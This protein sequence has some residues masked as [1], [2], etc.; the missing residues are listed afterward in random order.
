M[1]FNHTSQ[2]ALTFSHLTLWAL[3]ALAQTPPPPTPSAPVSGE[4]NAATGKR[5]SIT[6]R[7]IGEDG[8]PMTGVTVGF[9][10]AMYDRNGSRS[11]T[12]DED[13]NFKANN[14]P[15]GTYRV[16]TSV[17]GFVSA[18]GNV[19]DSLLTET[20]QRYRLG[21]HVTITMIKGG[22]I[23]GKVLDG[24]GQ[25]LVGA[26][27]SAI[28]VRD[29]D[30]RAV[31]EAQVGGRPGVSDDR[32]VYRL[33]GLQA[34]SYVVYTNGGGESL[35]M[36]A[37]SREVTTYHPAATRDTAQEVSVAPGL[38]ITGIDIRHRGEA[39][40]A[41][42]GTIQGTTDSGNVATFITVELLQMGTGTRIG[43]A[44]FNSRNGNSFGI[45][46]VPD[47]EYELVAQQR[48][49]PVGDAS[50][51]VSTPRRV[52]VRG[53]DVTGIELRLVALGSIT[54]RVSLEKINKTDCPITRRGELEEVLLLPRRE[55][56]AVRRGTFS[57]F[58]QDTIPDDKGEFRI[59]DLEAGR[60]RLSPQLPSDYWYVKAMTLTGTAVAPA[61]RTP[62]AKPAV[63]SFAASGITLKS[64][65]K[66]SG[67][68]IA[69]AEGAAALSGHL[70]GKKPASRMRVHLVPAEKDVADEVLRYA[71]VVTRDDA[72]TLG[73][74]APGKYWLVARPVPENESDERP[75][76]PMA[77]DAVAR[78]K[79]RAEAEAANNAVELTPCQRVK[80]Y[81]LRLR[82][83]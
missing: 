62:A 42:S 19:M 34:G 54:G 28:R 50:S 65:E 7:V 35:S 46:G 61:T 66:L 60:Y 20:S 2:L 70:E 73:N 11:V 39:G 36:L 9:F 58:L 8:Q 49:S 45:Y 32:G 10:R 55:D 37:G 77:W 43:G 13:G 15:A 72:F 16:M 63:P 68:T 64:G 78:L 52:T 51:L 69:L 17:P 18:S 40:H 41:V 44:S 25:P 5:G 59:R 1:K 71:E 26:F 53:G 12:T 27:V 6:G 81:S 4:A 76:K 30:G 23:T 74:L 29:G 57:Y 82:E 83:K 14:L 75:A 22:A 3:L 47:G 79:L 48:V 31:N 80:E 67:V 56:Q 24:N 38:E 33:Y 21:E